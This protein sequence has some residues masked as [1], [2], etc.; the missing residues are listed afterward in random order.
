M[1]LRKLTRVEIATI[2]VAVALV[3]VAVT[4]TT[5]DVGG[6]SA[7]A[8]NADVR[9]H[10]VRDSVSLPDIHFVAAST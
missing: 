4:V 7:V 8:R 2:S 9:S 5:G 3:A 6:A 1:I 10:G